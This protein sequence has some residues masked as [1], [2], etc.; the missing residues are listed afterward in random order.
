MKFSE[1]MIKMGLDPTG[2]ETGTK[3]V[4]EEGGRLGKMFD[5]IKSKLEGMFSVGAITGYANKVIG[6]GSDLKHTADAVGMSTRSLQ[7]LNQVA[8]DNGV[9][10]QK[11]RTAFDRL[12][13]TVSEA[14]T[15]PT[16][17][18]A[19][20][21]ESMGYSVEE[22]VAMS[23]DQQFEAVGKA[24]NNSET[25]ANASK[26]AFE[27]FGRGAQQ[28]IP[29][30]KQVGSEG[31]DALAQKYED[32]GIIMSDVTINRLEMLGTKWGQITQG[33]MAVTAEWA[34]TF[35]DAIGAM[36]SGIKGFF[37]S[38][39]ETIKNEG[40]SSLWFTP[41][42]TAK[43]AW[44]SAGD[45]HMEYVERAMEEEDK[46]TN[47]VNA[48]IEMR[49]AAN[50]QQLDENLD[51]V[52]ENLEK[53]A[54]AEEQKRHEQIRKEQE[55]AQK[56][57]E[58]EIA[59]RQKTLE[60]LEKREV[61]AMAKLA[62]LYEDQRLKRIND[63]K[64]AA[65]KAAQ[66]ARDEAKQMMDDA[67]RWSDRLSEDRQ[68]KA[69][70]NH[71]KARGLAANEFDRLKELYGDDDIA[72]NLLSKK[73]QGLVKEELLLRK[74]EHEEQR[75]NFE[76][77]ELQL[78]AEQKKVDEVR[79]INEEIENI[80]RERNN[81][82]GQIVAKHGELEAITGSMQSG[83]VSAQDIA[84]RLGDLPEEIAVTQKVH[85]NYPSEGIPLDTK[86]ID[87]ASIAQS[88]KVL[89]SLKGI[90]YR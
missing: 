75:A 49:T 8:M 12:G 27:M 25:A 81:I 24:L 5:G 39:G 10:A 7:T 87:F 1:L 11:M 78:I 31:I 55:K 86:S 73:K 54:N 70:E 52:R 42:Q 50:N 88:L 21:I 34:N 77:R 57:H 79:E 84:D 80:S 29:T 36:W 85:L 43:A 14:V 23:P 60:A 32:M 2:F 18:A 13:K 89:A 35:A 48:E 62:K 41:I 74:A 67:L 3:K 90:I 44:K 16:G 82:L 58:N 28:L 30:L 83:A 15:N 40:L 71:E 6:L 61:A 19:K 26:A 53:K 37:S 68:A 66:E 45:A 4:K 64:E 47:Q 33:M 69:R 20:S 46:L 63:R 22:F 72:F 65:N 9:S 38:L 56:I 59:Q 76:Q 51:K 17:K